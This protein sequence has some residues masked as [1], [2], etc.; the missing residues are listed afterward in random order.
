ME[1][2]HILP[3]KVPP[4][5]TILY[6]PLNLSVNKAAKDFT[7]K[8]FSEW[9][10]RQL[11]NGMEYGIELDDIEIDYRLSVLKPL[12][13]TWLISLYNHMNSPEGKEVSAS[14]WKKL[15]IF[16]AIMMGSSKLPTLD[17]FDDICPLMGVIPERE[18]LSLASLLPK[19]LESYKRSLTEDENDIASD[20]SEWE[21]DVDEDTNDDIEMDD[22]GTFDLFEN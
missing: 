3:T 7:R 13:A 2:N 11:T 20:D 17:P 4:N 16:D 19:E 12:H 6:Q 15:G 18:T 8:K 1:D 14:G 22:S 21:V 5:M 9:Y 10:T